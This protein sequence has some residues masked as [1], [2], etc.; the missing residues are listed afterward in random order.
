MRR[1]RRVTAG[2]FLSNQPLTSESVS[3]SRSVGRLLTLDA[4]AEQQQSNDNPV[5]AAGT[6]VT[7]LAS[8]HRWYTL[9]L[10]CIRLMGLDPSLL[11]LAALNQRLFQGCYRGS[12][13]SL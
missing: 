2:N 9:S 11:S 13:P 5:A 10:E 7:R 12:Y 1:G 8:I 6:R 4:S 3:H